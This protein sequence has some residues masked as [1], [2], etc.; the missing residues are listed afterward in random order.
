M[1]V[2]NL[3]MPANDPCAEQRGCRRGVPVI[4]RFAAMISRTAS[5]AFDELLR[6]AAQRQRTAARREGRGE[7][8][9]QCKYAYRPQWERRL[10]APRHVNRGW[11]GAL[12]P[13]ILTRL[14]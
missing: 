2:R 3:A 9:R 4:L 6:R 1:V 14:L 12:G 7:P 5:R 10:Y 8:G 11:I 13:A